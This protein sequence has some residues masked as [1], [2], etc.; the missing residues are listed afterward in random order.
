MAVHHDTQ[1][2]TL[3]DAVPRRGED[4]AGGSRGGA[5][6]HL[7]RDMQLPHERDVYEALVGEASSDASPLGNYS[8]KGVVREKVIQPLCGSADGKCSNGNIIVSH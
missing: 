2:P 7:E 6:A 8:G 3:K 1:L 4:G 5:H